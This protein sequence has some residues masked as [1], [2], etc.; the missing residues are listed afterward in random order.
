MSSNIGITLSFLHLFYG[1]VLTVSILAVLSLL[2][3]TSFLL[4]LLSTSV[5]AISLFECGFTSSPHVGYDL[6]D[7]RPILSILFLFDI[8]LFFCVFLTMLF[9]L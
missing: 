8:E 4:D 2:F 1:V 6:L 7:I 5:D 3:R 9:P